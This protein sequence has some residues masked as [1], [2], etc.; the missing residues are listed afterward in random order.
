MEAVGTLRGERDEAVAALVK[1][2]GLLQ[3]LQSQLGDIQRE[4]SPLSSPTLSPQSFSVSPT[5]DL[6]GKGGKTKLNIDGEVRR[7]S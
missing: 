2:E 3:D 6:C 5:A 1:V 7:W 4:T